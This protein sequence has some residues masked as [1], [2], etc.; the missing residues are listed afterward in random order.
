MKKVL[1]TALLVIGLSVFALPALAE[2]PPAKDKE[3][4]DLSRE[5]KLFRNYSG[6]GSNS[7]ISFCME[8]MV[9]VMVSGNMSN[10]PS[11]VQVYEEKN[12]KILPKKCN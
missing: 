6:E 5:K 1:S 12:G 10:I 4:S 2:T 3:Y 11:V 7:V 9:F 8:G